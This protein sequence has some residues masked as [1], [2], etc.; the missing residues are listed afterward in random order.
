MN[1]NLVALIRYVDVP[2]RM[3]FMG[4]HY[5]HTSNKMQ[6]KVEK[7]LTQTNRYLLLIISTNIEIIIHKVN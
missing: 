5:I 4:R 3:D 6:T 2:N 1:S 7:K